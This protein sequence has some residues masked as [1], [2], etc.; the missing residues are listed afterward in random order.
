MDAPD[1]SQIVD[2]GGRIA[3]AKRAARPRRPLRFSLA[4]ALGGMAVLCVLLAAYH[5]WGIDAL[6]LWWLAIVV[7]SVALLGRRGQPGWAMAI[8]IL[9]TVGF[10]ALVVQHG[11]N[12][13]APVMECKNHL[14][15]LALATQNYE[16][17]LNRLPPA[18]TRTSKGKPGLSWRIAILP[19][20]EEDKLHEKFALDEAWD[21]STNGQFIDSMPYLYRC[22][23]DRLHSD[24]FTSYLAFQGGDTVFPGDRQLSIKSMR[25]GASNTILFSE[26]HDSNITWSEPRDFDAE[27]MD[28]RIGNTPRSSPGSMHGPRVEYLDGS[29]RLTAPGRINVAMADGSVRTFSPD[30]DPE[31]LKQ[32]ANRRDGLPK[33]L[34]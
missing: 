26:M 8:C 15:M 34:P 2:R 27:H 22:P 7:A 20:I 14:K 21:G 24:R 31:V 13:G 19:F 32:M 12:H 1:F 23:E 10:M 3:V 30:T 33:E 18:A 29:R 16:S 5:A 9:A 28:W 6:P 17:T 4:A 11:P 25:D